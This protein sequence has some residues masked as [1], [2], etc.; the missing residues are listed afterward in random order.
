[1]VNIVHLLALQC[2]GRVRRV[3]LYYDCGVLVIFVG[4]VH[5]RGKKTSYRFDNVHHR[6]MHYS[7][8]IQGRLIP[9]LSV[10]RIIVVCG[11]WFG[12]PDLLIPERVFSV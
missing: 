10:K 6:M 4:C 8:K 2:S 1:M 3:L 12:N 9:V 7:R 5:K 11:S